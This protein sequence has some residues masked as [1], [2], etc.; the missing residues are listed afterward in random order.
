ME[1]HEKNEFRAL[2]SLREAA[3]CYIEYTGKAQAKITGTLAIT[4][5]ERWRQRFLYLGATAGVLAL[6]VTLIGRDNIILYFVWLWSI[7]KS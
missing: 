3:D 7:L 5:R 1:L 6:I 4:R 2:D